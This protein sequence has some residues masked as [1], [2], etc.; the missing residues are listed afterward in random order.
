[1]GS[2]RKYSAQTTPHSRLTTPSA[3]NEPR[4]VSQAI[5]IA[6]KGGVAALPSRAKACVRPCAK[7]RLLAG[8]QYC[9]ARVAV[10]K[11]APSPKPS[12]TR[13]MNSVDRLVTKPVMMVA[14]AQIRPHQNRVLRGPKRSPTQPPITWNKQIG[15]GEGREHQTKLRVA[16][17]EF[18]LD[19]AGRRA[20]VHPVDI[21]D[22]VHD[23]EHR[24]HDMGGLEPKPHFLPPEF[25]FV[26]ACRRRTADR[27]A[28]IGA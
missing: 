12:A 19:L 24:Q 20:D 27:S 15:I 13:A 8:V 23:A 6:I 2:L 3:M 17:V 26:A 14:A 11:V 10:G 4:Q 21:G 1:M 16:E 5:N 25:A 7:P 28:R 22:E 18:L 9:M